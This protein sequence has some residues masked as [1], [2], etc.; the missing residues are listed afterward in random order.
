MSSFRK[1][2]KKIKYSVLVTTIRILLAVIRLL[3]R[4]V[5]MVFM[6]S[7]GAIVFRLMKEERIK[8]HKQSYHCLWRGEEYSRN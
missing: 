4:K 1:I 5:V 6:G 2:R 8:N 7:L 3:P